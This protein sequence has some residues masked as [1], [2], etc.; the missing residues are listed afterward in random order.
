MRNWRRRYPPNRC[1]RAP[2][3]RSPAFGKADLQGSPPQPL[4]GVSGLLS[5]REPWSDPGSPAFGVF[6]QSAFERAGTRTCDFNAARRRTPCRDHGPGLRHPQFSKVPQYR[7]HSARLF[8]ARCCFLS[9]TYGERCHPA[10]AGSMRGARST[11]CRRATSGLRRQIAQ[12]LSGAG[13]GG[14]ARRNRAHAR[15]H[16][17][18]E[19]VPGGSDAA[20]RRSGGG[21]V[22]ASTA[23]CKR[24]NGWGSGPSRCQRSHVRGWIYPP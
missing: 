15:R 8:P 10:C 6:R 5:S 7:F 13:V 12:A 24:S 23:R 21:E 1:E 11:T 22:P 9:T 4:D 17:C 2:T 14:R 19:P 20:W 18:A 3:G 16:G